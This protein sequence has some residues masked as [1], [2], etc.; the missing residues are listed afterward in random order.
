[1]FSFIKFVVVVGVIVTGVVQ[2][3]KRHAVAPEVSIAEVAGLPKGFTIPTPKPVTPGVFTQVTPANMPAG[4]VFIVAPPCGDGADMKAKEIGR[5]L[6]KAGVP[7]LTNRVG[8][9][10]NLARV[11]RLQAGAVRNEPTAPDRVRAQPGTVESIGGRGFRRG[12]ESAVARL[13]A[14]GSATALLGGDD[15]VAA[16]RRA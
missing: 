10:F 13:W 4:T 15:R 8:E 7:F 3:K 5:R 11:G 14:W 9:F 12:T 2:W 1:M 16:G 6:Q